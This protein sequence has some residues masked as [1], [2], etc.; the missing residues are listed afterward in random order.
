VSNMLCEAFGHHYVSRYVMGV[1]RAV[2][3]QCGHQLPTNDDLDRMAGGDHRK[4]IEA[5]VQRQTA[6]ID[7]EWAEFNT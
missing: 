7:S 1:K 3:S 2:C 4:V 5:Y 6:G